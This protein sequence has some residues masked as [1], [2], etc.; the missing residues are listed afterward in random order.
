MSFKL[1]SNLFLLVTFLLLDCAAFPKKIFTSDRGSN[2]FAPGKVRF[3]F[4]GFSL[5]EEEVKTIKSWYLSQG[6]TEDTES[7][8][9]IILIIQKKEPASR[10]SVLQTMN[11]FLSFFSASLIPY[12][13]D[14][15]YQL[16]FRYREEGKLL[17]EKQ[18]ILEMH[19][20]RG[21]P[22]LFITIPFWPMAQ[23]ENQIKEAYTL[24][25]SL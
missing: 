23:F 7:T 2:P 24:E 25:K 15:A 4:V 10:F 20:W 9:E 5:Y 13:S 1:Y 14:L 8:K 19:Q 18:Y 16:D 22:I 6:F 21:I 11:W 17:R 3:T 12:H